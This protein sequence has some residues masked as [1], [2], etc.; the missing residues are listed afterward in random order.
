MDGEARLRVIFPL[1]V[2]EEIG[3]AYADKIIDRG[4]A[5]KYIR[6]AAENYFKEARWFIDYQRRL[7]RERKLFGVPYEQWEAMLKDFAHP[8]VA[9]QLLAGIP[10]TDAWRRLRSEDLSGL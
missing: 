5:R 4:G 9:E 2:L 10:G 1:N 8:P 7:Y 3:Q 6:P